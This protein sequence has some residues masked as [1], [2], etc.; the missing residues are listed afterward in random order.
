VTIATE[1]D[2]TKNEAALVRAKLGLPA[3]GSVGKPGQAA[4]AVFTDART[5]DGASFEDALEAARARLAEF[6]TTGKPTTTAASDNG[7]ASHADDDT[8]E[9]ALWPASTPTPAASAKPK[10]TPTEPPEKA[11]T[12]AK[13]EAPSPTPA[14]STPKPKDTAAPARLAIVSGAELAARKYP[15]RQ[16]IVADFIQRGNLVLF[17]GKPKTGKSWILLQLAHELDAPRGGLFLN[18]PTKPAKVLYLAL[19]DGERRIHERLAIRNWKPVSAHF[20]SSGMLPL[21]GGGMAQLRA[22]AEGF[23]V[24]IVDSL[25][26][27]CGAK[28]EENNNEVMG[29]ILQALA[30]FAHE[31]EKVVIVV[32][33][34]T[35]ASYED[36]FDGIRGAGSI[37]QAYDV[38]VVMQRKKGEKEAKLVVESRDAEIA[39]MTIS[40]E[41]G[42]TGWKYEGDGERLETI[43]AGKA[44]VKALSE[45]GGEAPVAEL[46]AHLKITPQ[47]VGQQLNAAEREGLVTRRDD[48]EDAGKK[49]KP[50]ALWAI[51]AG[52]AG[53][54]G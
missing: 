16:F 45:L 4:L 37:R 10:D 44:V 26:V 54:A 13:P 33:H 32:H 49:K 24:V 7:T 22:T 47:A 1:Y 20:Y 35:K 52:K 51:K 15:E 36:A 43:R 19:E 5:I 14:A 30:D 3:K 38:G 18:K 17:A 23:D 9:A 39:D 29:A 46:A 50:R 6:G 42:S 11:P 27:A 53:W 25:R 8:A 2:R 12:P 28:V 34:L 21:D 31:T 48:P 40:F 41:G